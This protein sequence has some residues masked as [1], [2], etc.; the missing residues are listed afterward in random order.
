MKKQHI[1]LAL[2]AMFMAS[3]ADEF[4]RNFEVGRPELSAEYAYLSDYKALKEYV[5]DPNFKLGIGT[6]AADYAKQGPTYVITNVNFNETVAGNAMKMASCVGDDGNMNFGTVEAYVT[7]A[8]KA[9]MNVYGHT[10]AWHAQQPVKWLNSLIADKPIPVTPGGEQEVQDYYQDLT[11]FDAFPYYVMGYTPQFSKEEGLISEFPGDWYQYFIATGI[12]TAPDKEYTYKITCEVKS[13]KTGNVAVQMRWSWGEDPANATLK[14]TEGDWHEVSCEVSGVKGSP[15]DII[16]Q[17]GGFDGRF[18]IKNIKVSHIENTG[19]GG[20]VKY[21]ESVIANGDM[22]GT[23][24]KN[25]ATKSDQGAIVYELFDGVG[26]DGSRGA[27]ITSKGGYDDAWESQFWIVADEAMPEGTKVRV[28]FDYKADG[29][30]AGTNVDTQAHFGPGEYQHWACAGTVAFTD[31]W[32][33]YEKE[34]VVD[35]SMAG[36]NGMKSVAFNMSPNTAAGT[37]YIDNVTLEVEKE[38]SASGPVLYMASVIKNGDMEGD[39]AVN[40]AT[41]SDQ[42]SIVYEIVDG[43]GK[44]GSRGAKISS[45]GGYDDAW[46]SQFWIVSDEVLP[47]GAKVHVKFDYKADGGCAG[48]NVDT[49]A[50]FGPGEYQHWACAGTVAFTD[51]WQTYEKEFTVDASMAGA[52]GMKSIAFNMSPNT[53]PGNYY[54][55]N[56]VLEVEKE[57]AGG[58]IPL[59]PQE[60]KDTLLYAMDKWIHGMMDACRDEEGNLLVKAWDVVNEPIGGNGQL[61]HGTPDNTTD[62]FWQDY[63]GD[64]D[65]VRSAVK[66]ARQYGGDDLKLFVN[67]YNLEYDWDASGNKKLESLISWINKW[68]SDGV[69]KIDGIGSQMHISCYADAAEAQKRKDLIVKSFQMMAGTGKLVRISELDMGYVDANGNAVKTVEMTEE[70]HHQMA[71][72]Y[73]W[74]IQQYKTIIPP[75]QQWG[76]TLWCATDAPAD[77]GWRPGEPV[78]IWDQNYYRKHV[79]AGIADGLSGE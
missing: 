24:A 17:P 7:E 37:Y 70:Q 36:A 79:Y 8:A 6:D 43:V 38:K 69:T 15:C 33:H 68:E 4:D 49:Q 73:K 45:K 67:D 53:T 51:S 74:I 64:L 72:F 9:G 28:S 10:L 32:Q 2:G 26:K 66:F 60:K 76:I 19:G 56:V 25:F 40:F 61:Q 55:D 47:E 11:Q 14:V 62:F 46:E 57:N 48:T 3:C 63:L 75:A 65:Y 58:G 12:T 71:D 5:A 42:G 35:A 52:N 44:D 21:W 30:C 27:K 41:K 31:G 18:C 34:F 59:T 20:T 50:H 77:S 54:I 13:E 29:G 78:G 22:E 1:I 39:D 23:D 16:F